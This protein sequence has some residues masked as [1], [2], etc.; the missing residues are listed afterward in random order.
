MINNNIVKPQV[1]DA[2]EIA[3]LIK[4]GWNSAYKGI[5]SDEDLQ[6][7]NIEKMAE[8]WKNNIENNMNIYI[9]K[10]ENKVLGVIRF[11]KC[12][13]IN[14]QNIGEI[15]C[16][17]VRPEEKRKGIGSKLF[18]FAKNKLIED[19]YEKMLIWCLKGNNQGANFYKKQGGDKIRERDFVV[20]GIKVREEGFIFNLKNEEDIKLIKPTIEYK[21]QAEELVKEIKK[22][23]IDNKDAFAGCSSIEK[24]DYE[25]WLKK[26]DEDLDFENIKPGRVP[27]STY[28]SVRKSDNKIIGVVNIRY[29]FN[30]YL[31]NYGGHIG[32]LVRPVER[33]K[34]YGYKNLKLALDKCLEIP[35]NKV[36]IT[37]NENNIGSAKIIESCG[38]IYE[39]TR[40]CEK[41]NINLKRYWIKLK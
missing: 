10:E 6:N 22:Y 19:G 17:Y 8:K 9:Y 24:Y 12:E 21:Q 31:E 35:I 23:D 25:E 4:D 41:E 39:E 2:L 1:K 27:A 20:R 34:G 18:E 33:R 37:C 30:E 5:I 38:G 40:F 28:F 14:H 13:E 29:D 11:G 16:L 3:K 36:L 15:F 32:Y 26:I 7:M